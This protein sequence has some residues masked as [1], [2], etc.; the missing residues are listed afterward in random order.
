MNDF[1]IREWAPAD[2]PALKALWKTCFEDDDDVFIDA[3]FEAYLLPGSCLVA[4]ADGQV[5]SAMYAVPGVTLQLM[6]RETLNAGYTYALATLPAYRGRGIG[7]AVYRALCDK[8]LA[9]ADAACVIPAE[10]ALFP[11]YENASGAKPAAYLREARFAREPLM[12]LH[13]RPAV[14]FPAHRYG[15]LRENLLA[16]FPHASFDADYYELHEL[17]GVEF[18][19]LEDGLAAAETL[20]GVCCVRELIDTR[21]DAM[22]ALAAVAHWCPAD[23]YV[24]RTPLFLDGPGEARPYALAVTADPEAEPLPKDLWWGFGLE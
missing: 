7:S 22:T 8:V 5:V 1:T 21:R 18:F 23:E 6:R 16:G 3:F 2:R 11:L 10:P 19:L 20:D 24:V 13:A 17:A 15:A 14:R 12:E 4:E 9:S